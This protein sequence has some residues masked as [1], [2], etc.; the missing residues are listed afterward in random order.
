MSSN[1]T[2]PDLA[3]AGI[4]LP[5][6]PLI[7][8]ALGH[9]KK[10][11]S[12]TTVNHCIRSAYFAILLSRKIPRSSSEPLDVELIVFSTIMHDLGWATDKTLLSKDKRVEV[13]GANMA[14]SYL[15][16]VKLSN[17]WDK[18]RTQLMWDAIALHATPSFAL[19]KEAEVKIAHIGIMADFWGPN[20]PG[21][22]ITIEENKE[23]VDAFPRL[24][25]K[26]QFLDIMCGLCALKPGTTYDNFVADYGVEF[27]LDGKGTDKEDFAKKRF[28][29]SSPQIFYPAIGSY[30]QDGD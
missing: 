28:A 15:E 8:G 1:A 21:Y 2:L 18:H 27:G 26:E 3:K 20:Y 24:G 23:I 10:Y 6:T 14:R 22:P 11:T 16:E 4:S 30:E 17:G 9:L 13:D 7:R 19:H 5:N 29:L 25:F 12:P